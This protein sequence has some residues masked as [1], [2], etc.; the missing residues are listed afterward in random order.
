MAFRVLF[1]LSLSLFLYPFTVACKVVYIF[2]CWPYLLKQNSFSRW[3]CC[4]GAM[5][6]SAHAGRGRGSV[7]DAVAKIENKKR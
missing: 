2:I 4:K 6:G 5:W 1:S 7:G 3:S